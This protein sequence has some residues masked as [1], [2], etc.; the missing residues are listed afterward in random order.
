M[1]KNTRDYDRIKKEAKSKVH[2]CYGVNIHV[3]DVLEL[4]F[5]ADQFYA[6]HCLSRTRKNKTS[7]IILC[8]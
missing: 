3:V 2:K 7:K 5:F 4:S 1:H 6:T 8:I